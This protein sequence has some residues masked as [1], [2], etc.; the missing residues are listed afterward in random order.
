ML[1]YMFLED[2]LSEN[3]VWSCEM[4]SG[5]LSAVTVSLCVLWSG[6]HVQCH[7]EK[8]IPVSR[9]YPSFAGSGV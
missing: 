2:N 8:Q 5:R 3:C 9:L 1:L 6:I 7:I 4:A